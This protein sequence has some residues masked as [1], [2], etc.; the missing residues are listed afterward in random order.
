MA[1]QRLDDA[2]VPRLG[3]SGPNSVA[4]P[5]A[6]LAVAFLGFAGLVLAFARLSHDLRWRVGRYRMVHSWCHGAED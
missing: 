5:L 2:T 6:V 3:A 4:L 1:L